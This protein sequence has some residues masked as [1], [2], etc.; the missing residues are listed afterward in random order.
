M[1]GD[2]GVIIQQT[3]TLG[4]HNHELLVFISEWISLCAWACKW[5]VSGSLSCTS[6]M[7]GTISH[8]NVKTFVVRLAMC[9]KSLHGCAASTNPC[10][11]Q[12]I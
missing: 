8:Q 3:W 2:L 1:F 12:W 9:W 10:R 7:T 4:W 5:I 11:V 6:E